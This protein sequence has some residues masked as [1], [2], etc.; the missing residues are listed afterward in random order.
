[1]ENVI[2]VVPPDERGKFVKSVAERAGINEFG[3]DRWGNI[4][5][6]AT[7][8]QFEGILNWSCLSTYKKELEVCEVSYTGICMG[9]IA[10]GGAYFSK[11]EYEN[12][13]EKTKDAW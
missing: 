5:F 6:E 1:M 2:V 11:A 3:E 4:K 13:L 7:P 8:L 12:Y 10:Y 9:D